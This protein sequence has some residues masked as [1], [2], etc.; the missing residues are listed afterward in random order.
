M[1]RRHTP[2]SIAALLIIPAILLSSSCAVNVDV[3]SC[4]VS[5]DMPHES[6]GTPGYIVS[7]GRIRCTG[8]GKVSSVTGWVKIQRQVGDRWQ[9]VPSTVKR[10]YE[11]PVRLGYRY[12]IQNRDLR[13]M[14]GT[15]RSAVKLRHVIRGRVATTDWNYSRAKVNPCG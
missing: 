10:Q 1:R 3:L 14:R 4:D 15:F 2:R 7:K 8:K 5:A 12:T 13:C 6:K 9:D 11:S